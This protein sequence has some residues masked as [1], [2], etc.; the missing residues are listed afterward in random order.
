MSARAIRAPGIVAKNDTDAM[1]PESNSTFSAIPRGPIYVIVPKPT[2]S[3]SKKNASAK[4]EKSAAA[5]IFRFKI[6]FTPIVSSLGKEPATNAETA[7]T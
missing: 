4:Q 7:G 2:I 5:L 1:R 6:D 3:R